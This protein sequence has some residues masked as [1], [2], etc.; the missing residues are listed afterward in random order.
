MPHGALDLKRLRNFIPL[1]GAQAATKAASCYIAILLSSFIIVVYAPYLTLLVFALGSAWHFGRSEARFSSGPTDPRWISGMCRGA[2]VVGLPIIWHTTELKQIID[3][4]CY[5]VGTPP[6]HASTWLSIAKGT[7]VF[8]LAASVFWIV[9]WVRM[10]SCHMHNQS[11]LTAVGTA[12]LVAAS[13]VLNPLF[14]V[15]IYF[16][17]WHSVSHILAD[18]A[19]ATRRT[20]VADLIGV[21]GDSLPLLIPTWIAF[22][23]CAA[24]LVGGWRPDLLAVLLLIF[25]AV[26]T[27]A[28]EWLQWRLCQFNQTRISIV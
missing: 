14:S 5:L 19:G 20:L 28:H 13:W 25:F 22:G 16:L 2:F 9:T 1:V 24:M 6:L 26:L 11:T 7:Q 8:M 10:F 18:R 12:A 21:H 17:F 27:P 3:D 4:W 23:V 15:G